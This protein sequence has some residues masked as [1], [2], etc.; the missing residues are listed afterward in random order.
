MYS[1]LQGGTCAGL[2][3]GLWPIFR[4][5]SVSL[6]WVK[7]TLLNIHGKLSG[8]SSGYASKMHIIR[9]NALH[10]NFSDLLLLW[11]SHRETQNAWNVCCFSSCLNRLAQSTFQRSAGISQD[12]QVFQQ[13]KKVQLFILKGSK[14]KGSK[15]FFYWCYIRT[16]LVSQKILSVN[17]F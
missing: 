6:Q 11:T 4:S 13:V 1:R 16:I 8:L 12:N 10:S 3:V 9:G 5:E 7:F 15:R 17:N 14:N 2:G